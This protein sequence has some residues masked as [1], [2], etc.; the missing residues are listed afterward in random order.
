MV[1]DPRQ[2][3]SEGDRVFG[4][5]A[6]QTE[7][8]SRSAEAAGKDAEHYAFFTSNDWQG[9]KRLNTRRRFDF[10]RAK[11]VIYDANNSVI[12]HSRKRNY[13]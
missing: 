4:T 9:I 10:N 2:S 6:D 13:V 12:M 3:R 7:G 1:V 5:D 8:N 11:A